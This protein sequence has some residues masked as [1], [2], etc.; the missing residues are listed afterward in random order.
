MTITAVLMGEIVHKH[1]AIELGREIGAELTYQPSVHV[2]TPLARGE[3]EHGEIAFHHRDIPPKGG[4]G[5]VVAVHVNE[6]ISSSNLSEGPEPVLAAL[7]ACSSRSSG[8]IMS[9]A[10][11][12]GRPGDEPGRG[13]STIST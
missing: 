6:G 9:S 8:I 11:D 4:H 12:A 3:H 5:D 10:L 13:G 7:R 1:G 2:A